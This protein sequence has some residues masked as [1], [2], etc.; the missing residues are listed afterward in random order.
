MAGFIKLYRKMTEW[1]WY[2][3]ANVLRVYL[4]LLLNANH[5]PKRWR[6]V[7]IQAG[8][9]VTSY[10]NLSDETGITIQSVRTA[11]T[12]LISTGEITRKSTNRFTVITLCNWESY[13]CCDEYLTSKTTNK[14][15]N[16]QQTT[17]K[18]LT[19]N[20]N[21]KNIENI[22]MSDFDD[23]LKENQMGDDEDIVSADGEILPQKK[24]NKEIDDFFETIWQLYPIKK[25]KAE[26]K[27]SAKRELYKLGFDKVK[28]AIE[29]YT[30]ETTPKYY[31]H[32]R[33]FFNTSYI[34]Y[35][36]CDSTPKKQEIKPKVFE[37]DWIDK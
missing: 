25:G 16:N 26:V 8:Q 12:K 9:K 37:T 2:Q 36:T 28:S 31:M 6:G 7:D 27:P 10:Q 15:T 30:K 23:S 14:K 1:E 33:R 32:G 20:K 17:N 35:V 4:H 3:D 29:K 11:I 22:Y 5:K 19:T 13:Q 24:S 34:D 21:V 18:Q